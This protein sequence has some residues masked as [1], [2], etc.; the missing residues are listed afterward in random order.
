LVELSYDSNITLSYGTILD[1]MHGAHDSFKGNGNN[2][3]GDHT[4]S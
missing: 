1:I 4:K 3:K 2:V